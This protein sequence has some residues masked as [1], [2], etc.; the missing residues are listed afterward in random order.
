[1]LDPLRPN[2]LY[3]GHLSG[4]GSEPWCAMCQS[5]TVRWHCDLRGCRKV[6]CLKCLADTICTGGKL[7]ALGGVERL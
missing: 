5:R 7:E 6:R 4:W 1:M 2:G 3:A